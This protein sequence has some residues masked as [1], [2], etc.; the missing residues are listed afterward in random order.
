MNQMQEEPEM[1]DSQ[2]TAPPLPA[3]AGGTTAIT[4]TA[5][6]GTPR[7]RFAPSPVAPP[8]RWAEVRIPLG[9]PE[10]AGS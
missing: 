9:G 1:A 3:F 4:T 8:A 6:V 10:A 2:A 7:T 5:V